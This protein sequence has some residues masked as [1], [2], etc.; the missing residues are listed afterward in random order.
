MSLTGALFLTAP[1]A[2][3]R[4]YSRDLD[5]IAV[6]A[7]LIRIAGVFQIF[8]GLQVVGAGILRGLGDTRA[9]LLICLL[10]YWLLVSP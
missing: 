10:G 7:T 6:A 8:G 2:L 9:P 5:V 1:T 4:L 3:A